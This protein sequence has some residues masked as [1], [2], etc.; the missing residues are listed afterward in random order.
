MYPNAQTENSILP[1]TRPE[2]VD[3]FKSE[4]ILTE[5]VEPLMTEDGN[6][7]VW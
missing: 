7:L 2:G 1:W 6:N 5:A 3:V 4:F